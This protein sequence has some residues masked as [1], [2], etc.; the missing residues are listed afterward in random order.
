MLLRFL[1]LLV[2]NVLPDLYLLLGDRPKPLVHFLGIGHELRKLQVLVLCMTSGSLGFNLRDALVIVIAGLLHFLD[3][4]LVQALL[5]DH[6]ILYRLQLDSN[7]RVIVT[8]TL[9][10]I[11]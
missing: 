5:L 2:L 9:G 11:L 4:F 7:I 10:V 8:L 1:L 3:G 6:S